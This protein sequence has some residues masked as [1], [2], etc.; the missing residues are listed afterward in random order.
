MKWLLFPLMVLLLTVGCAGADDQD[1]KI[2]NSNPDND[3]W[4]QVGEWGSQSMQYRDIDGVRFYVFF[5]H[6]IPS[7]ETVPL[8]ELNIV[9]PDLFM[10]SEW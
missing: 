2:V 5:N 8:N 4:I 9:D 6:G 7:M 3:G 10:E 1:I